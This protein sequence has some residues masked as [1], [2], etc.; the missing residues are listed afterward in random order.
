MD[1][2]DRLGEGL[3]SF[4]GK[5]VPDAALDGPVR[6]R[7]G[8]SPGIGTR[9]RMRGAVG[10][11]F[12]GDRRYGDDRP[13]PEGLLLVVIF[14]VAFR[15]SQPPAVVVDDDLDVATAPRRCRRSAFPSRSR[16]GS[17]RRCPGRPSGRW[18]RRPEPTAGR[19]ATSPPTGTASRRGRADTIAVKPGTENGRSW[20]GA[21]LR[22]RELP[23]RGATCQPG[24]V[25]FRAGWHRGA[26]I[27]PGIRRPPP[28]LAGRPADPSDAALTRTPP[29]LGSVRL[30]ATQAGSD[31]AERSVPAR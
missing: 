15:Q 28:V 8:E 25:P 10:V 3:R 4:L 30:P 12:Q 31:T 24:I 2:D 11:A 1:V 9:F 5:V 21:D 18:C 16:R 23:P 6:I 22:P 27:A 14:R 7:A 29:W 13:S 20:R 17:P 26:G 19:C